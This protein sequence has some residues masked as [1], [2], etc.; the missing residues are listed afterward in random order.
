MIRESRSVSHNLAIVA[1]NMGGLASGR[2]SSTLDALKRQEHTTATAIPKPPRPRATTVCCCSVKDVCPKQNRCLRGALDRDSRCTDPIIS[3]L[4]ILAS[5]WQSFYTTRATLPVRER[6]FDQALAIYDNSLPANHQYR[7]D[8]YLMHFAALLVLGNKSAR[9]GLQE[10]GVHQDW[11][12][13]SQ[14]L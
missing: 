13:T 9:S 10:R 6:S 14:G 2:D 12:E 3:W 7:A 5:A 11:T 4:D 8:H 1:Q